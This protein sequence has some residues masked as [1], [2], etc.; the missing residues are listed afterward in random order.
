M[1][2]PKFKSVTLRLLKSTNLA[3]ASLI[4]KYFNTVF[5]DGSNQGKCETNDDFQR[6]QNS[7]YDTLRG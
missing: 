7:L 6:V 3:Q 5:M 2:W 1:G 4:S